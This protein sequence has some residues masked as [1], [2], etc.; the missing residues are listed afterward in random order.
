MALWISLAVAAALIFSGLTW[1]RPSPQEKRQMECRQAARKMG[2]VPNVRS[3]SEWAKPRSSRSM[4]PFYSLAGGVGEHHFSVWKSA[5][6]WVGQGDSPGSH[7]AAEALSEWLSQ[8][9]AG[10]LGVDA[11][12]SQI[13]AWWEYEQSSH[14]DELKGWLQRCPRRKG[15]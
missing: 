8:A 14:L 2:L 9:P 3:V 7:R 6:D 5:D 12:A 1:L 13:G 15:L 10:V 11:N 4:Q